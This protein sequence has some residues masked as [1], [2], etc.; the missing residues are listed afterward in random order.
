MH[1]DNKDNQD[2][3][4]VTTKG[5]LYFNVNDVKYNSPPDLFFVDNIGTFW[6]AVT[7]SQ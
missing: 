2:D 3:S 1:F 4:K 7:R 5:Y 6:V